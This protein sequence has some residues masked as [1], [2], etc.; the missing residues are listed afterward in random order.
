MICTFAWVLT[1][2]ALGQKKT[3]ARRVSCLDMPRGT[4]DGAEIRKGDVAG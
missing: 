2:V 1:Q 4:P 3:L